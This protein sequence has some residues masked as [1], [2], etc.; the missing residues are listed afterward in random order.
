LALLDVFINR[1]HK[2]SIL[3]GAIFCSSK[4]NYKCNIISKEKL[5]LLEGDLRRSRGEK[6]YLLN[7]I[8]NWLEQ[9][10]RA[11]THVKM[12]YFS[13]RHMW[14]CAIFLK[15]TCENVLFFWKLS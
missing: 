15:D 10:N 7:C 14:K 13:E 11:K 5:K 12:Y 1:F 9:L 2:F 4:Q 8:L 6:L 3:L